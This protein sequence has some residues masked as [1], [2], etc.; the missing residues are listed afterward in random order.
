[1]TFRQRTTFMARVLLGLYLLG[2]VTGRLSLWVCLSLPQLLPNHP[3]NHAPLAA[4]VLTALLD[5][6][7][8]Q[9]LFG[10]VL[11]VRLAACRPD[12]RP[13]PLGVLVA[14]G[15]VAS[16]ILGAMFG[17]VQWTPHD[18]RDVQWVSLLGYA[19]H[20]AVS[21][22]L[23]C[24]FLVQDRLGRVIGRAAA[25]ALQILLFVYLHRLGSPLDLR[26]AVHLV[27]GAVMIG[28]FYLW[29][30]SL[31]GAMALHLA[32]DVLVSLAF[33]ASLDGLAIPPLVVGDN[34][35]L[36]HSF[37]AS[38]IFMSCLSIWMLWNARRPRQLATYIL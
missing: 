26:A 6:F 30:R 21:E 19:F 16:M 23:L 38:A 9:L 20:V 36:L 24:R 29:G 2:D 14:I 11:M 7:V 12:R 22:E 25:F 28:S 37:Q 31:L 3:P 35:S 33:G 5:L 4:S 8:A 15:I 32:Y 34:F 18:T 27:L 1:M 13:V 10:R 17:G